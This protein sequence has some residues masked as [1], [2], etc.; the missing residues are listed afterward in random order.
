MAEHF[1]PVVANMDGGGFGVLEEA[2]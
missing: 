1:Y 2:M